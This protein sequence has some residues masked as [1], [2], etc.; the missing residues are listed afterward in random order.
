MKNPLPAYRYSIIT[1]YCASVHKL[2]D[3]EFSDNIDNDLQ[4]EKELE[5]ERRELEE[6]LELVKETWPELSNKVSR[7]LE[8]KAAAKMKINDT[9]CVSNE[10]FAG[11]LVVTRILI[12]LLYK[13]IIYT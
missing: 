12:C 1:S 5:K 2:P 6:K 9:R 13:S 10:L 11:Q 8:K 7:A 4:K 3:V